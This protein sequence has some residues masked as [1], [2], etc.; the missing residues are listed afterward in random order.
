MGKSD[1]IEFQTG[2]K[3]P[4]LYEDRSVIA[5]DKPSGWMLAPSS[6]NKTSR[7]LQVALTSSIKAGA[8]WARSRN[9][10]YLHFVHRLDAGTTGVLLLAKS[11]GAV[12]AYSALFRSRKMEKLYLAVVHGTPRK[13]QWTCRL[14]LAPHPKREG[15]M[16]VDP[17]KG[18]PAETRF[19]VL[20]TAESSAL[21]EARPLTGRTH[22]IRIHLTQS[23]HPVVG[24]ELYGPGAAREQAHFALRAVGLNYTD[25]FTH[26][27]IRIQAP[28]EQFV[29]QH[30]FDIPRL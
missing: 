3:I 19:R 2:E 22:Q 29:R 5:V 11:P 4:I 24:D 9:L 6:W 28:A 15:V 26:R 21:V 16:T 1:C 10:D 14:R 25:P 13:K 18:K 12:S 17:R 27:P 30:G 23:G 8:Y 7:N 20:Q